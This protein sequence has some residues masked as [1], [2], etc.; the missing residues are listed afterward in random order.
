MRQRSEKIVS[1]SGLIFILVGSY[2]H[3]FELLTPAWGLG[4]N[5]VGWMLLAIGLFIKK[6]KRDLP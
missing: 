2:G 5:T 6:N 3:G 1:I 4:L